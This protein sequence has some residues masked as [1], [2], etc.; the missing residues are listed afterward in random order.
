MT[1]LSDPAALLASFEARARRVETPCGEGSLVW[2][3]WGDG[4]PL[5]LGHGGQGAWSHW[6]R[7]IDALAA[8]YTNGAMN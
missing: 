2:R 7:N 4:P 5:V 3:I 8:H 6:I 1:D